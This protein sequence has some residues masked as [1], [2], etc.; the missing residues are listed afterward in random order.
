MKAA[1][2]LQ[3]GLTGAATLTLLSEALNTVDSN[4]PNTNFFHK[5]G[6]VRH[7]KKGMHQKGFK[8]VKMYIT[9]ASELLSM[10]GVLG[11]SGLG[12]KK[13]AVLRGGL[14]GALAGT[15]VAFLQNRPEDETEKSELW[16]RRMVTIAL[17]ILGGLVAGKAV[18]VIKKKK[19]KK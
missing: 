5:K 1:K 3:S 13:N 8:A 12:K 14:V 18:Q 10:A 9:L 11:I 2:I 16:K 6:I 15:A 4:A 19:K 17:Y 7:L